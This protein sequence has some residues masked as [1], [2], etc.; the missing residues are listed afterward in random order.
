MFLDN[1]NA[2][3][4]ERTTQPVSPGRARDE[5]PDE[6][7]ELPLR[8]R[9]QMRDARARVSPRSSGANLWEQVLTPSDKDRLGGDFDHA[10]QTFGTIGMWMKLRGVS[11]WRAII[12][13]AATLQL[14]NETIRNWLLRD[15]AGIEKDGGQ[16]AD[17]AA[18][19]TIT[20]ALSV[21]AD[22][23][24]ERA[25]KS[26]AL[27]LVE[28]PRSAYWRGEKIEISWQ[29]RPARW[30][31]FWTLCQVAKHGKSIDDTMF[32]DDVAPGYAAKT[33]CTLGK[34]PEFPEELHALIVPAGRGSLKLNLAKNEIRLF[35]TES[36]DHLREKH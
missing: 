25:V 20:E 18:I 33:K 29:R 22:E 31:F 32:G 11:R 7:L 8:L 17:G 4:A 12:E 27:V 1:D 24:L 9:R 14:V 35:E 10:W 2:M 34:T 6:F 28:S 13:V 5:R 30:D 36:F 21:N 3:I 16:R 23:A 19:E 15:V 26:S